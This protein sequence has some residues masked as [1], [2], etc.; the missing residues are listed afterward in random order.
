MK[1]LKAKLRHQPQ[2][3][4][5]QMDVEKKRCAKVGAFMNDLSGDSLP[6]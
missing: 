1:F 2:P 3:S 4:P 5:A 6:V